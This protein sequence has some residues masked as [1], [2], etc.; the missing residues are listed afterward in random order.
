MVVHVGLFCLGFNENAA[1]NQ[2]TSSR[3]LTWLNPGDPF[4]PVAHTW[5]TSDPVPGLLAAGGRLDVATLLSA[6]G[7]G[8]FPWFSNGDPPLW[9]STNPRMVLNTNE[10]KLHRSLQREL[11]TLLRHARLELRVNHNFDATVQACATALRPGQSGTWIIDDMQEAYSALHSQGHAHSVEAWVDGKRFGGLYVVNIGRMVFGESMFS[12]ESNGS[13][14]A[15]CGLVAFCRSQGMPLIDCQ[16][17][18]RHLAS[19]GARPWPRELFVQ[20]LQNLA[21]QPAVAWKFDPIYWNSLFA[22]PFTARD[23]PTPSAL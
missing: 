9:W 16:Q 6:Y 20:W 2:D 14:F 10:F 19:L 1:M 5:G 8:I 4:P 11:R 13:K 22:T 23:T 3:P 21:L 17:Q 18:T 15:L 12:L 7:Q